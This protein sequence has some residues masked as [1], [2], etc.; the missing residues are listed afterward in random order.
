MLKVLPTLKSGV[1]HWEALQPI[2]SGQVHAM[3]C[4]TDKVVQG[5]ID[6][7]L[8]V[9]LCHPPWREAYWLSGKSN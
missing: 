4:Y 1:A 5:N 2:R 9:S 8:S 6:C 3:E 7:E